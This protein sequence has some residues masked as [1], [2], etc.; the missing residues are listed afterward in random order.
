MHFATVHLFGIYRQP[1][2]LLLFAIDAAACTD[3][4]KSMEYDCRCGRKRAFL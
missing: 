4:D 3:V 1:S 2:Y